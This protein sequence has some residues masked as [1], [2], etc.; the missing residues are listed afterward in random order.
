MRKG[1]RTCEVVGLMS[2]KDPP[3]DGDVLVDE[4]ASPGGIPPSASDAHAPSLT[5]SRDDVAAAPQDR[6]EETSNRKSEPS[7][8]GEAGGTQSAVEGSQISYG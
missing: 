5:S 8:N 1:L 3:D 2:P 7:S 4:T 6:T